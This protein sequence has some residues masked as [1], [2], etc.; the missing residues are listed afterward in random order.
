MFRTSAGRRSPGVA[1]GIL[2]R[3]SVLGLEQ[4]R[5]RVQLEPGQRAR[6]PVLGLEPEFETEQLPVLQQRLRGL[7]RDLYLLPELAQEQGAV[8][9]PEEGSEE[10]H[11]RV[12]EEERQR[13]PARCPTQMLEQILLVRYPSV[14]PRGQPQQA[15]PQEQPRG[16][17]QEQPQEQPQAQPQEQPQEQPQ[18]QAQNR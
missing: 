7:D 13:E 8:Q 4:G 5:R 11:A 9:R 2:L 12:L 6:E 3:R 15:Q 1:V 18:A 17:P 10:E 16:Q 14:Q